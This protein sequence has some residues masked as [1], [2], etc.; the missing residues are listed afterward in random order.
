M[1]SENP[2]VRIN[3]A[4]GAKYFQGDHVLTEFEMKYQAE[5]GDY[6]DMDKIEDINEFEWQHY[7]QERDDDTNSAIWELH[8]R[9]AIE[10][11][12]AR[13]SMADIHPFIRAFVFIQNDAPL[14]CA[15]DIKLAC[16]QFKADTAEFGRWQATAR[17]IAKMVKAH[18]RSV[19]AGANY[20]HMGISNWVEDGM[21]M[22]FGWTE[23]GYENFHWE[24]LDSIPEADR[25]E[26]TVEDKQRIVEA[27]GRK[28][29]GDKLR[30]VMLGLR[31]FRQEQDKEWQRI[32]DERAADAAAAAKPQ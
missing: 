29:S 28:F 21:K 4:T 27:L 3:P 6:M 11:G 24:A 15:G 25:P 26:E 30:E 19:A 2:N 32:L 1:A 10:R 16:A 9:P 5:D 8:V 31:R 17:Y 22:L 18:D 14:G 12:I 20:F 23:I 7:N 13:N